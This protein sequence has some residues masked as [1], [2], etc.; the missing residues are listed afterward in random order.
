MKLGKIN[1]FLIILC[2]F[3]I[4]NLNAEDKIISAPIINLE[5]LEPSYEN[6]ENDKEEIDEFRSKIKKKLINKKKIILNLLI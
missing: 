6:L 4:F 2:Y 1:L 5:N 3:F